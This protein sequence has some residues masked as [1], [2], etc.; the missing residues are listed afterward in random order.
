[1][2]TLTKK[3]CGFN[4]R[5]LVGV[6]FFLLMA[7]PGKAEDKPTA[8]NVKF[9]EDRIR[10]VLAEHCYACHNSGGVNEGGLVLDHRAALRKGGQSG[11]AIVPGEPEKSLL[12]KVVRHEIQGREMPQNEPK[13]GA[14]VI[15]DLERWIKLGAADPRNEPPSA[16]D[17]AKVS[18]W[19]KILGK[20]KAWWSFQPIRGTMPPDVSDSRF[21]Q[22]PTDR[23]IHRALEKNQ[24][25]PSPA[26]DR[27][28]LIRR[29]SYDLLGLPPTPEEVRRFVED[30][31][32]VAW[33][34]AVDRLLASPHYGE[35][36]GRHWLDVVRFGESNGF[37]RNIVI[38]N[39]WPF[40]DYVIRSFNEDKPFDQ[41][42]REHLAA[43]VIAAESPDA[44]IGTAF[45]VCGPYDNVG[46]QDAKQ[47]AQIRANT[48]DEMIRATGETFLGLTI[49]CARCHDHKFDPIGQRDYYAMYATLA[50]VYHG[51]RPVGT[52]TE[53]KE[54]AQKQAV[55]NNRKAWLERQ[56]EAIERSSEERTKAQAD[57]LAMLEEQLRRIPAQIA[58]L[59]SLP[60]WWVGRF[61]APKGPFHVFLGGD[62]QKPGEAVFPKSLEALDALSAAYQLPPDSAEGKRRLA[63]ANWIVHPENPLAARV[64]VNRVWQYHFGTGL[65]ETPSDFGVMGGKPSHPEL[66]DWLALKLMMPE[67]QGG[68]GW[69]LKPLHRMILLSQTY[70]QASDDRSDAAAQDADTRLLWR[71]PPRRLSAEEIRDSMLFVAGEL[72]QD[73]GGPGFRLYQYLQDNVATYVPLATHPPETYRRA[74]YHQ[75]ARAA[76]VDLLSDFDAPDP[77]FAAP[78]RSATVTPLQ[79]LCMM[80]HSFPLDMAE[81]WA[82][83]LERDAGPDT[84]EQIRLAY[85]QAY[86]RLPSEKEF[87]KCRLVVEQHGLWILCRA[88]FN[89]NEFL[90]LR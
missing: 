63:L 70:R 86:Q 9:F 80:N 17:I 75:N 50:G 69:R 3:D 14:G 34:R 32:I 76:R 1:V 35:Q 16:E 13:L 10:P 85:R 60:A 56:I 55:L 77:A 81:A 48:I 24:L 84:G 46:N 58:A 54:L 44:P 7:L 15:K 27:A 2:K 89:S 74:V 78:K 30:P 22:N 37:E 83:R 42:V 28:V 5:I 40:R 65:V 61:K 6:L 12:L 67:D 33:E 19:S 23:F 25:T 87:S 72:K 21:A 64:L 36:W 52:R 88:I 49:G 38:E 41:F 82:L 39:L 71:F 26:A 45:L 8:E 62:P 66:L 79:A 90:F 43:D 29:A 11:P 59:P 57:V 73:S 18:A 51:D 53:R 47:A 4:P 31:S 68:F 20:R